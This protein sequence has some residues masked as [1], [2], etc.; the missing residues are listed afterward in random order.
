MFEQLVISENFTSPET[1][2]LLTLAPCG[3][4]T[5]RDMVCL[6]PCISIA[7][8]FYCPVFLLRL[9]PNTM[10][11]CGQVIQ[12]PQYNG[13]NTMASIQWPIQLYMYLEFLVIYF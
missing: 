4:G 11:S 10:A 3:Q 9:R 5:I 6:W 13:L 12:W 8:Y 2:G 7:L 1:S